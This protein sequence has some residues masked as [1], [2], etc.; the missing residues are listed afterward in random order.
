MAMYQHLIIWDF[1]DGTKLVEE[2]SR[3]H[4]SQGPIVHTGRA[5]ESLL[6]M[7]LRFY[8]NHSDWDLIAKANDI[9]DPFGD[10]TG[11]SLIIPENGTKR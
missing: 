10:F 6:D 4:P 5:N 11:I 2:K 1:Q 9:Q 8:G 7:S 3:T